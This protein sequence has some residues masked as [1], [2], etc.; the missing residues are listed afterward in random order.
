MKAL[1][2]TLPGN[3][4]GEIHRKV[5]QV[6]TPEPGKSEV[7]VRIHFAGL[8]YFD[9]GVSTGAHTRSAE[10]SLKRSPVVSGIEMAGIAETSGNGIAKGD[11]VVGYTNIW[12]GPFYH[13]TSLRQP[14]TWQSSRR[15]WRSR[16]PP[17]SSGAR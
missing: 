11:R 17:R 10:R 12:R 5:V 4:S 3:G 15:K 14:T 2:I 13:A 9:H 16:V 1:T 6:P 7:L 8:N